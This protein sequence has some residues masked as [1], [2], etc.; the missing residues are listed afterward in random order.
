MRFLKKK[1]LIIGAALVVLAVGS[2]GNAWYAQ[3]ASSEAQPADS[4]QYD[5][6][7]SGGCC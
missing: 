2:M 6:G 4:S 5:S 3:A 7:I 1:I